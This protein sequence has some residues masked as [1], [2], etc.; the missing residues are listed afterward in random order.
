M[1]IYSFLSYNYCML[2]LL[3]FERIAKKSGAKRI[4]KQALEELRDIMDE[5]GTD[6]A[7]KAVKISRHANK[8]TVMAEDVR[9]VLKTDKK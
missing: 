5:I 2:P 9:F 4:S 1:A 3:P 6:I 8:R 7:E